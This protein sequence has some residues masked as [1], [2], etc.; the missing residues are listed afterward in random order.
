MQAAEAQV[1]SGSGKRGKLLKEEVTEVGGEKREGW[2]GGGRD[3]NVT[4]PGTQCKGLGNG[5]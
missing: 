2:G 5:M 3:T 4:W 1:V